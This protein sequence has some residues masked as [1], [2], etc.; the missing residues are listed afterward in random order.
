MA[1]KDYIL[2]D[3]SIGCKIRPKGNDTDDIKLLIRFE[4]KQNIATLDNFIGV[5]EIGERYPI[6]RIESCKLFCF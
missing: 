4:T 5:P 2:K 3:I 1:L 6:H